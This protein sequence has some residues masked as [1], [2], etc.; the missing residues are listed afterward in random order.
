[1]GVMP[2]KMSSVTTFSENSNTNHLSFALREV[3]RVP[4][5]E[6]KSCY[7]TPEE[8]SLNEMTPI[9]CQPSLP[10]THSWLKVCDSQWLRGQLTNY[11]S[12][13]LIPAA[14]GVKGGGGRQPVSDLISPSNG[15]KNTTQYQ[16]ICSPKSLLSLNTE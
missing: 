12:G 11:F 14:L 1:M 6:A 9:L 16:A 5:L 7:R 10:P 8:G 13:L 4:V 3:S 15:T 2:R